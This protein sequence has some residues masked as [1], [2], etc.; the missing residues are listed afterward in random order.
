M[1]ECAARRGRCYGPRPKSPHGS[2]AAV[3][4]DNEG[5]VFKDP[6]S[7]YLPGTRGRAW[8]KLKRPVGTIDVVVTGAEWGRGKRAGLLSDLIF[9]VRDG[10]GLVESGRVY[11]GLSDDAIGEM[12]RRFRR[13]TLSDDGPIRRVTPEVVLEVAFDEI[14]Q[15]RRHPSGFALRFPRIVRHRV[16][17]TPAEISTVEDLAELCAQDPP[18]PPRAYLSKPVAAPFYSA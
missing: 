13:Q 5:A 12:T 16:D 8:A 14:R 4:R 2:P 15:S 7:C 9:A 1:D 10:D 17:L 11:S 18:R 3:E 6:E